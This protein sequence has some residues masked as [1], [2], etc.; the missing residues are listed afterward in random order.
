VNVRGN[1]KELKE[2]VKERGRENV[3]GIANENESERGKERTGKENE[4]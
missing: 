1:E 4:K 2:N 3:I